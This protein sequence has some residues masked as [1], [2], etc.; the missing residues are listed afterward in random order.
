MANESNDISTSNL[1]GIAMY[2]KKT[3]RLEDL[4]NAFIP[5]NKRKL[6][7]YM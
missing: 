2:L 7:G 1:S 5:K 6:D 3:Y 4:E